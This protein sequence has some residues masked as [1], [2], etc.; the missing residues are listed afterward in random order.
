M[1]HPGQVEVC[2]FCG[3]Q[4]AS[5]EPKVGRAESA[6]HAACADAALLDENRW[7]RI[8]AAIEQDAA[9]SESDPTPAERQ[10]PDRR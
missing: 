5:D 2:V 9:T 7:E 1:L 6:A 3:R 8:A 4:I 10:V